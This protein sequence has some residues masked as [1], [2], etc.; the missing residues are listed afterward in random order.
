MDARRAGGFLDKYR[1]YILFNKNLIISGTAA[2]FASAF[3][4]QVHSLYDPNAV[5][6]S[7][8]ALAAEYGVYIPFFAFLFYR[9]NRQ[10]YVDPL[11]GQRDSK[12]L[13]SDMKKLFAAFS[14]S[15][16]IYSM[17]RIF[18]HYQFLQG[19]VEPYQA[20]MGASLVSWAVFFVCINAGV[21]LTRLFHK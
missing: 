11:T 15:E 18:T 7:I 10:R 17:A 21:K 4:A 20:S 3:I 12:R 5:A 6:N 16:V 2:F 14:I 1:D 19:G 9:D 13:R 8:I